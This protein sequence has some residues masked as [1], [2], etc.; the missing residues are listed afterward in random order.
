MRNAFSFERRSSRVVASCL[1]P[2]L[3]LAVPARVGGETPLTTADVVRFLKVGISERTI[4]VELQSRGFAEALDQG[5]EDALRE[6][7]AT[8]TLVVAV[9]RAAP[10]GKASPPPP[11]QPPPQGSTPAAPAGPVIA[12]FASRTRTVRVPV[13][14]LDKA[15]QP[16]VGLKLEDFKISD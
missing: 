11:V 13:S 4:L 9:R 14:V 1:L 12:S 3:L 10:A 2:V 6:A 8:E 5:K 7:G 15:G 16:V